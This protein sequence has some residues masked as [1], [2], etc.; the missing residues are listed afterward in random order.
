MVQVQLAQGVS[1]NS[2]TTHGII[3]P[4]RMLSTD[5]VMEDNPRVL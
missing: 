5:H 4:S 1:L 2:P 3:Y